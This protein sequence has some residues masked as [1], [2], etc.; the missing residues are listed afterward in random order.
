L[1]FAPSRPGLERIEAFFAGHAYDK[2][3]HDTY[4]LGYT[5]GGVQSFD[6]RGA[7]VDSTAGKLIILHPDEAHDGRAGAAE[8]FR[9][10]M[11]YVEPRLIR[12]ALGGRRSLPFVPNAVSTDARLM[13]ALRLALGDLDEPLEDLAADQ[14][15]LALAEALLALDPSAAARPAE[16]SCAIAVERGRQFLDAHLDRTVG[17]I[18]LEAVT[19]LD[20]YALARHFRT[21]LGTS[22]YRYL[23]MRRLDRARALMREGHAISDAAYASGFA[24]QSHMTRQF[25]QAFGLPPGRWRA[26]HQAR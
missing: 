24:D 12:E 22:P 20:R 3:R 23:T 18:E 7:R 1:R 17:S 5:I 16:P 19:G 6:Y 21:L 2:H 4:A 9:Y 15:V 11:L 25:K 26:V 10:R 8:G 13:R 14:G